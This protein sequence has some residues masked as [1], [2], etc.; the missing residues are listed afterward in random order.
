LDKNKNYIQNPPQIKKIDNGIGDY[1]CSSPLIFCR[2]HSTRTKTLALSAGQRN[3]SL[4]FIVQSPFD[5]IT[6]VWLIE[7]L[8]LYDFD[9]LDL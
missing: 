8:W 4:V 7:P 3:P 9:H 6:R 5:L 1:W 2:I